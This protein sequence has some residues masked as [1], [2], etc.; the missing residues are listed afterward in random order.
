MPLVRRVEGS[1][2][3]AMGP[4]QAMPMTCPTQTAATTT[5]MTMLTTPLTVTT[6]M[7]A[8]GAVVVVAAAGPPKH[9]D[10]QQVGDARRLQVALL[11][12]LPAAA[13]GILQALPAM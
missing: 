1:R 12:Q 8:A 5:A 9:G 4:R 6:A 10:S 7:A 11:V 13:L 3:R 2:L